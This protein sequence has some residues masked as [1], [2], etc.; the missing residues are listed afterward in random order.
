MKRFGV[1]FVCVY[2]IVC[3]GGIVVVG[4]FIWGVFVFCVFCVSRLW[5]LWIVLI[6]DTFVCVEGRVFVWFV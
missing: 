2:E 6:F 1:V 3:C 4:D 5:E